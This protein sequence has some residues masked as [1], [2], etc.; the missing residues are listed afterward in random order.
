[1][2]ENLLTT[3]I[4]NKGQPI[5]WHDALEMNFVL[6]GDMEV[7]RNNR[8]FHLSEGDI[9]V[10]NRD[11]VHSISS[12]SSG[13]LYVQLHFDME[14]FNQYIPDIWT[15]LFYCSP[16]NDDI[17]SRNLKTEIKSSISNIIRLMNEKSTHV[18]AEKEIIYDC[19]E[20]LNDLKMGFV[21]SFTENSKLLSEEQSNRI[22]G[23]IDFMY[24]NYNRKLTLHD[25]AQQVYVSDDYLSKLL[26][27]NIGLGF[28]ES[29]AFIRS[30]MSIR[31]L[32]NTDMSITEIS[33]ECGFSAPKYY[34]AA[35]T[36][37]YGCTPSDYRKHNRG[38][39]NMEREFSSAQIVFDE[40]VA[41]DLAFQLAEKY[42]IAYT[43]S[44]IVKKN[45]AIDI[46]EL[47]NET[48]YINDFNMANSRNEI[49]KYVLGRALSEVRTPCTMPER[50]T[51]VWE[52]QNSINILIVN[53]E[54][55][56]NKEYMM[57]I[58]GLDDSKAYLYCREQTP[59]V[60]DRLK[61]MIRSGRIR[62]LDRS[63]IDNISK[64][65]IEYGEILYHEK[66]YMNVE[67]KEQQLIKIVFQKIE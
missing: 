61:K 4:K 6:A 15:T 58:T 53:P 3:T 1:M 21:A 20:I 62:E 56:N 13:L 32:L 64:M 44:S 8:N 5:H 39:F 45:I 11:D 40:G 67:L 55:S 34:T 59:D 43:D 47:R 29:L 33:Y 23:I 19:I 31:A 52:D 49:W 38:N 36:K 18:D 60:P 50:N 66:V 7:V 46:K 48:E 26:K 2:I 28:K 41:K 10:L 42:E 9:I 22:W 17:I 63:L 16:E 27:K 65:S 30:E 24:D 25:V 57:T 54:G 14:R 35:F 37:T 12:R 51:F